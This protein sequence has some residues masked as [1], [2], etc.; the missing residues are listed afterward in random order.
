V[1]RILRYFCLSILL[2]SAAPAQSTAGVETEWDLKEFL[3]SLSAGAHR[4]QPLV[5]QANPQN[6]QNAGAAQSYTP[7]WKSVQ[8]EIRYL[9]ITAGKLAKHPE[10]LTLALE[11]YLR[12]QA[13]QTMASSLVEGVRKYQNP[14][15]A[16]LLQG[17]LTENLNNRERVRTYLTEL[18]E[19]KEKELEIM[20]REAQRC[21]GMLS[22]QPPSSR[23]RAKPRRDE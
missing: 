14:A 16:D 11:T 19:T 15:I 7:Q 8:N 2:A 17:A 18:A 9:E 23:D 3:E 10:R 22:R 6:W 20:D 12:L 4:L 5:E 21:R 1:R 13:L